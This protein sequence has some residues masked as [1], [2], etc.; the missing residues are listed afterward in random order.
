VTAKLVIVG[1]KLGEPVLDH[2]EELTWKCPHC[3][4]HAGQES[5]SGGP[6]LWCSACGYEWREVAD[7]EWFQEE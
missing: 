4:L 3:G 2:E 1:Y 5:P 6:L 7:P